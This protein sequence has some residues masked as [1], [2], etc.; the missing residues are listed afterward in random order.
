M[1]SPPQSARFRT[2]AIRIL[3]SLAVLALL[4]WAIWKLQRVLTT[5]DWAEMWDSVFHTPWPKLFLAMLAALASYA[6]IA[7]Y[8]AITFRYAGRPLRPARAGI[9]SF[10]IT[11][12]ALNL[13]LAMLTANL[14][15]VR[16]LSNENYTPVEMLR[17][18]LA[19]GVFVLFGPMLLAG[20]ALSLNPL[21]LPA[22]FP[23][24][25]DTTRPLGLILL[26]TFLCAVAALAIRRR[27][28]SYR[29]VELPAPGSGPLLRGLFF[30]MLEWIF[31]ALTL[32]VLIPET[33]L[34]LMQL[35]AI[36]FL[37]QF[38]AVATGVPGG[39]GVFE[40][41][42]VALA[43]DSISQ[44]QLLGA[45]LLYRV[46]YLLGPFVISLILFGWLEIHRAR[47]AK[48]IL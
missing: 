40:V 2:L 43:P 19:H 5:F 22:D 16:L 11:S 46:I 18:A 24:H 23:I 14:A 48:T 39:I 20:I 4:I 10:I 42:I 30:S 36:V 12:F 9:V 45:I 13:G 44:S 6:A 33:G 17:S 7:A 31:A 37:A 26:F 8:G 47:R 27:P 28:I 15:R 25:R 1:D 41:V 35:L 21:P 32:T 29:Q 38:A 34:P 3:V